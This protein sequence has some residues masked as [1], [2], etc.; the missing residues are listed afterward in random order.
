MASPDIA[1]WD[2]LWSK[3]ENFRIA[4]ARSRAVNVNVGSL[5]KS[6]RD[7]VQHYFREVRPELVALQVDFGLIEPVDS[8]MQDLLRLSHGRNS[9]QSYL[10]LLQDALSA[11][12]QIRSLTRTA[13]RRKNKQ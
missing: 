4:L 11:T 1:S 8:H 5:R 2:L 10:R 13:G 3:L 6:A 7:I 12:D 9:K